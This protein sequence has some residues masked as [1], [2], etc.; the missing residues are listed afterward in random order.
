MIP[1]ARRSPKTIS[2]RQNARVKALRRALKHGERTSEGWIAI[3]GEHLLQEAIRSGLLPRVIFVRDSVRDRAGDRGAHDR[4]DAKLTSMQSDRSWAGA[5]ILL[6]SSEIF[7]SAVTT[8]N[9]QPVA[10]LIEPPHFR[11][12]DMFN[13]PKPMLVLA[14]GLKDPGNLGTLVRSAEA[15]AATGVI[16]LPGTVSLWNAKTL[17]ASAGSAFRLPIFALGIEEA[18]AKLRGRGIRLLAA[19]ARDGSPRM[20]CSGP[21]AFLVGNEGAGLSPELLR[22]AD[23]AVTISYPG[24]VESLNAAV[25]GSILLYEAARQRQSPASPADP[26]P[27]SRCSA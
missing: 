21:V 7:V 16:L 4:E 3:E 6:L 24:P 22:L 8:E 23:E 5:E 12:D 26:N 1:S 11:A 10:A 13:S 14:A 25:A 27:S 18:I 20:D 17:R 19:V 9:P 15:F 2:S